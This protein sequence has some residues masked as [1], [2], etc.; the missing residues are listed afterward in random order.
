MCVSTRRDI[1]QEEK[2]KYKG[3]RDEK[4]KYDRLNKKWPFET[5]K[6]MDR[7]DN[8]YRQKEAQ[9]NEI[10]EGTTSKVTD[11]N[12]KYSFFRTFPDKNGLE[13]EIYKKVLAYFK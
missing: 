1:I 7:F 5:G 11:W 8:M 6:T 10:E 4:S 3:K 13:W 9:P 12:V 2:E